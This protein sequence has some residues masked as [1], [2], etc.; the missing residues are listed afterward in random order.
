LF[1]QR[2][3]EECYSARPERLL[4]DGVVSDAGH[5][6]DWYVVCGERQMKLQ[7]K[8]THAGHVHIQQQAGSV[9]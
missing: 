1:K 4:T 7:V 9:F 3:V 6:N 5:K 2:L 8:P